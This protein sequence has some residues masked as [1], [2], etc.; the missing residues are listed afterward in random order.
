MKPDV[1]IDFP[2]IVS[3]PLQWGDQ[4]SFGHVNNTV[5]LRWCE[6]ARI[7]YL[8]RIGLWADTVPNGLG[9]ILAS[10]T[11]DYRRPLTFPDTIQ[12][13]ARVTRIGNSS[14]RMEHRI[15]SERQK[16]VAADAHSTVV[17]LDYSRNKTVPVPA[18]V[19][20]GIR[21]LEGRAVEA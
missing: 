3:L 6:T 14:F 12:I 18:P 2:V 15:W 9:P 13:G 7:H 11:C 5:Y 16:A 19:R 21:D 8:K 20:Q 10:I 4:D 17:V 1:L